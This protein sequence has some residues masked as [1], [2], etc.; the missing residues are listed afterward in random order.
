MAILA[1]M[2]VASQVWD[3]SSLPVSLN[4]LLIVNGG[5]VGFLMMF[6]YWLFRNQKKRHD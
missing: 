1:G 6:I 3:T 5:V 4:I 2:L